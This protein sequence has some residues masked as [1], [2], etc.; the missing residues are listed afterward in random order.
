MNWCSRLMVG[1]STCEPA[2]VGPPQ[3]AVAPR[4]IRTW[5][6]PAP[7]EVVRDQPVAGVDAV[8]TDE[9]ERATVFIN[10]RAADHQR[11]L[12]HKGGKRIARHRAERIVAQA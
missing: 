5:S 8:D 11:T 10:A 7:G 9:R 1:R 6:E 12:R 3:L 4:L 2:Q